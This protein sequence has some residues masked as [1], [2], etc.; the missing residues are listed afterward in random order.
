MNQK[1]TFKLVLFFL[2]FGLQFSFAQ[3]KKMISG[4]VSSGGLPVPGV[5]V[6]VVGTQEGTSTDDN[7]AY[8]I[9]VSS[10]DVLE[11]S[12]VGMQTQTKKVGNSVILNIVLIEDESMLEEIVVLGYGQ[13]RNKNELTGNVV[14]ISGEEIS[15]APMV[16]ADQALQ[17]KVAGLQI[18]TD[19][20]T[21]GSSQQIRIRGLNSISAS[22][23][24][25]IVIDG[26]PV[27]NFNLSG[28][29]ESGSSLSALSTINSSDIE[30]MTVL[31]DAGATAVYGA[32][33]ANGVILITTKRGKSGAT[34][35]EFS[36][37][38]GV[39]NNAVRGPRQ[40]S[41]QEKLD[42]LLEAFN[43]TNNGGGAFDPN[44]VY[45]Q[46]I[47]ASPGTTIPLQNWVNAGKPNYNWNDLLQN[48]DALI[49]IVNLSATGGDDKSSFYASLGY[50]KTEGSMIGTDF[51]RVSGMFTYDRQLSDRIDF[52]FSANVSNVRQNGILEQGAFFSNPNMVRY[53]MSPWNPI[54][55]PDG[56]YNITSNRLS[57]LHNPLYT[58]S[59]NER[60]NDVIRV[61]NNNR[62]S[63][64]IIEDL[65]FTTQLSNDFTYNFYRN[66][67]NPIHGDGQGV[68]GYADN[69]TTTYYRYNWQNGF[70]Y[71]FYLGENHK[72]DVKALMEY[73]KLKYNYLY[74]YGQNIPEGFDML[75]NA[76]ADFAATTNYEDE[77]N[78]SILG[79]LN[80]SYQNKY[81][82]DASIRREGNSKF[83]PDVRWG[84]FWSVGLGWNI[85]NENFLIDNETVSTLRLRGSHGTNGNAGIG[86]NLYQTLLATDRY[87]GET[88][89]VPSRLGNKIT[90]EIVTKSD[91]GLNFG[92]LNDRI[93]G[94]VAYYRSHTTDLL[95]NFPLTRTS[96]FSS[97]VRNIGALENKG[98]ELELNAR[99]IDTE[100]FSWTLFGN[101]GTVK[102]KI[103][104]M[105]NDVFGDKMTITN[106]FNRIEEGHMIREWYMRTYAGVDPQTGEAL[107]YVDGEGSATTNVY[108]E[109][110]VVYQGKSALPTYS[111]GF[112]TQVEF[113]GFFAGANFAFSG[114][115]KVY[116]DWGLYV[117]GTTATALLNYNSTDYISDRWQQPG[118]ITNVPKLTMGG[119]DNAAV[120]TRFLKDGDFIRLRDVS[121][122][123]NFKRNIL[124]QLKLSGLTVSLRG[125]NLVTW[126]KDK[127][128][129][130][131]PEV[132]TNAGDGSYGYVGFVSP[133]VKSIIFSVNVKF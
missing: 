133:P 8:S 11:F 79:L 31:K 113:H 25:L 57:G 64:K 2:V 105:P 42:Y 43:N 18:A 41:G 6:L 10:A 34:R 35:Y 15:K 27:Y 54:Y 66:Y 60:Y 101:V 71:R 63:Y 26:I 22:N 45:Q 132:G 36:S 23:S 86:R 52:G 48:K 121:F 46:L 99:V 70:D 118:D 98:V 96:G 37:S 75:A 19:S 59:N 30:S 72:F 102:N 111:G 122:G 120:S 130:F 110:N 69:S 129:K 109:A 4:V 14:R 5:N 58:L 100:N 80:Y 128:L 73:E 17:G 91:V 12:Y 81:L 65:K 95:L 67:A 87:N 89:F 126:T 16:S 103:T 92:F 77:S 61:L 20:G 90:W 28:D 107:W 49:S 55:E 56:S 9:N 40:L 119:N 78:L 83:D 93:S 51:R 29:S 3:D 112:G 24:P 85:M 62:L 50:N 21:P 97:I 123:Y 84:T 32:R 131:D 127:S 47:T 88:G 94:S 124:D 74:G 7:G 125:T 38:L 104:E 117:Q 53:F 39:Q 108:N 115:N 106:S 1:V 76:S 33:G 68:G 82:L 114:G 44:A 116:E 13:K